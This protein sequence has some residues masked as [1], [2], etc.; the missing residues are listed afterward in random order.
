MRFRLGS[1]ALTFSGY[2]VVLQDAIF[3]AAIR[4]SDARY[5]ERRVVR[6]TLRRREIPDAPRDPTR[7]FPFRR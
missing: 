6:V 7:L 1:S 4:V 3:F 2:L 5:D